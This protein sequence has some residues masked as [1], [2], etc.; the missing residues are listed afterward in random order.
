ML[1]K[2]LI[3]G[4]LLL[5]VFLI[6]C[7]ETDNNKSSAQ[8]QEDR[9]V[10]EITKETKERDT[11]TKDNI[12]SAN[13]SNTKDTTEN[14]NKI[15]EKKEINSNSNLNTYKN[16]DIGYTINYPS[17]WTVEET[18][19]YNEMIEKQAKY[20][21]ICS[22]GKKSCLHLGVQKKGQD[23]YLGTPTGIGSNN[24]SKIGTVKIENYD[25]NLDYFLY[26]GAKDIW[27]Q[28]HNTD[29]KFETDEFYCWARFYNEKMSELDKEAI[30]TF[31]DLQIANDII[32][33]FQLTN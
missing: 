33:S 15:D 25:L 28:N 24:F 18:N 4:S 17:T 22:E 9:E 12:D 26:E 2:S 19:E 1:K 13:V 23:W 31:E 32:A 8:V 3:A 14:K 6:G 29:S 21:V 20:I 16:T 5:S 27:Y 7:E 30:M 10:N 11:R